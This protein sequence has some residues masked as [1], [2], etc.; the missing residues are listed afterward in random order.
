MLRAES[1]A[2]LCTGLGH[3]ATRHHSGRASKALGLLLQRQVCWCSAAQPT[4]ATSHEPQGHPPPMRCK[5]ALALARMRADAAL[6]RTVPCPLTR[7]SAVL[8]PGI[9]LSG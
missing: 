5:H 6:A 2:V 9:R 3:S 7:H 1:C 4:C 8:R